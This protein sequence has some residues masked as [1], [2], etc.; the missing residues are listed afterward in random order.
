MF[1]VLIA[2]LTAVASWIIPRLLAVAGTVVV[3]TTV[4]TPIFDYLQNMVMQRINGMPADALHFLQFTGIPE[5]ISIIFS[6]YAM[7]IGMKAAKAAYQRSG[8]KL[9]A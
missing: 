7:A 4:L 3:S 9:N 2:A 8:S 1:Q 6:A 5:A